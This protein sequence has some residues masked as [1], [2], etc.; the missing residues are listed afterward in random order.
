MP[1]I[2]P[3]KIPKEA[4]TKE[5]VKVRSHTL[6]KADNIDPKLPV[7]DL[8]ELE[9]Q[10]QPAGS[11]LEYIVAV[12]LDMLKLGYNYQVSLLGGHW[13]PGGSIADFEVFTVPVHTY[14]YCQGDY[15]HTRGNVEEEDRYTYDRITATYKK[16]VVEIWEHE[17][18]TVE[19]A[20]TTLRKLLHI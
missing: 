2:K 6:P 7:L 1:R 5:T 15:W 19:M 10:G 18:L 17:A 4:L 11:T 12:A 16:P 8:R 3:F 20:M 9:I 14:L 13:V